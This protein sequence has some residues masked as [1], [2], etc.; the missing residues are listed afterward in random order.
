MSEGV[1]DRLLRGEF[2]LDEKS[3][4]RWAYSLVGMFI[5]SLFIAYHTSI[6][7][8]WNTPSSGL[9]KT[10]HSKLISKLDGR[11]YFGATSNSQSWSMFAP[12]PN[13]TNV[14]IRVLVE[15]RQGD[16]WD[17]EHDIYGKDRYPY[18][19]YDRM[20]KINRRIDG[21]KGYQRVYGAWM[22][23]QWALNHDGKT[24][25]AVK[26]VK[27]Y[28]RIPTPQQVLKRGQWGYDPWKLP[29]RQKEQE[30]ILCDSTPHAQLP[31]W[32]RARHGLPELE[33]DG[34]R[35]INIRTWWDTA[36]AKA[37]RER[38]EAERQERA[39]KA[40]VLEMESRAEIRLP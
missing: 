22:C 7:L 8:T 17:M 27:K 39:E 35:D 12:N 40:E 11:N 20:G 25:R 6:L 34:F 29:T 13:R 33:D 4:S 28:T 15:D 19:F 3:R 5:V 14:F 18:W 23:R 31:N 1:A 32:M 30:T 26:F 37:K 10:F 38:F 2:E 16:V 9:G 36:E 24:P 21:K